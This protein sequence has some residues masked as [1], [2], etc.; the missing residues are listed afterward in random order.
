[1]ASDKVTY[2]VETNNVMISKEYIAGVIDSDGSISVCRRRNLSTPR[3]YA[4]RFVIQIGWKETI[5]S[6]KVLEDIADKYNGAVYSFKKKAN[7]FGGEITCVKFMCESGRAAA[8]VEDILPFLRLK[9]KQGKLL[10]KIHEVRMKWLNGRKAA[11]HK[12]ESV[13]RQEDA[14]YQEF[15]KLNTKNGNRGRSWPSK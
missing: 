3:G 1:M 15:I 7:K 5:E 6:R 14:I 12:P 10:L 8:M 9:H 13:W 2:Y 4:Y 11:H